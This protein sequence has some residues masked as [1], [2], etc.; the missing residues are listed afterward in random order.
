M[1]QILNL[2]P[3]PTRRTSNH[4][5][6]PLAP[7]SSTP[8]GINNHA[9]GQSPSSPF[10]HMLNTPSPSS[11]RTPLSF[12]SNCPGSLHSSISSSP[13]YD[14][15]TPPSS[16]L[17]NSASPSSPRKLRV[18][19]LLPL[20][21]HPG[22]VGGSLSEPKHH[23]LSI[24]DLSLSSIN[25]QPAISPVDHLDYL[26]SGP[27][28]PP[29]SVPAAHL[30]ELPLNGYLDSDGR[31]DTET[32]FFTLDPPVSPTTMPSPSHRR[33]SGERRR[34]SLVNEISSLDI[35]DHDHHGTADHVCDDDTPPVPPPRH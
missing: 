22:V 25:E 2:P 5:R 8:I 28:S 30:H 16:M 21:I 4:Q 12:L 20:T 1:D 26:K 29:I 9:Y 19:D 31:Y 7:P 6:S 27:P 10:H 13:G 17:G 35:T 32:P 3:W 14:L 11:P 18:A 24:G 33:S 23:R 34:S 15:R